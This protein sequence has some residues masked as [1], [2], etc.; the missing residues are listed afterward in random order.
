MKAFLAIL[1]VFTVYFMTPILASFADEA[2]EKDEAIYEIVKATGNR[3]WRLNKQT[4]EVSVCSLH[5]QSLVCATSDQAATPPQKTYEEFE[6]EKKRKREE[7]L[8]RDREFFDKVIDAM[9]LAGPLVIGT[10]HAETTFRWLGASR[11]VERCNEMTPS[12][13]RTGYLLAQ[14]SSGA[15]ALPLASSMTQ[16]CN[17]QVT[18]Q[19]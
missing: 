17:G 18:F 4:G 7:Q 2:S 10:S 11:L 9:K 8:A 12:L 13:M 3:I 5:G 16:S 15:T 19:P 6:A 14:P 1:A